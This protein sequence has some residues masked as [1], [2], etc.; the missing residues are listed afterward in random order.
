MST[1]DEQFGFDED[2]VWH[3]T[4]DGEKYAARVIRLSDYLG[5]LRVWVIETGQELLNI[6]THLSYGALFGPD[7]DDV[8]NWQFLAL[9]AIDKAFPEGSNEVG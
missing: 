9:Q 7:I 3:G 2:D 8:Q 5:A 4:I 1:D 6:E